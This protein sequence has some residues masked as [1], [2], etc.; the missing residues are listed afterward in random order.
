MKI[1]WV[2][3]LGFLVC[4]AAQGQTLDLKNL[5][6]LSDKAKDVTDVTLDGSLLKFAAKFLS[7][8]DPDQAKVKKL[9]AE[10]KGIYVKT[11][12]FENE[13]EYTDADLAPIRNQ[14]HTPA[15]SRIVGVHS[16]KDHDNAEIYLKTGGSDPGGLAILCVNPKEL[17]VVNIV[18]KIDLDELSE[19]GGNFGVPKVKVEVDK[20]KVKVLNPENKKED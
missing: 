1:P 7:N 9:V 18:G 2:L 8:D 5:D 11:Y 19:L 16:K 6:K 3:T 13:G 12:E 14:L 15:W 4:A 10:L 20:P 17:V